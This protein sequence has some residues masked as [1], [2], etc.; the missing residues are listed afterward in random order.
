M[1]YSHVL[2]PDSIHDKEVSN[3]NITRPLAAALFPV[4][5]EHRRCNVVLVD[6]AILELVPLCLK[7]VY[8]PD[9]LQEVLYYS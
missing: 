4:A 2:R 1:R 3:S 6:G 7:E 9:D 5:L 8:C